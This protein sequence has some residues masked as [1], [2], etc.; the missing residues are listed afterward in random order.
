MTNPQKTTAAVIST[1]NYLLLA[2][3]S[4]KVINTLARDPEHR[5]R[6]RV[7]ITSPPYY[8]QRSYGDSPVEIGNEGQPTGYLNA[9][10]A[11]FLDARDLLTEDGHLWIVIGDVYLKGQKCRLPALLTD[12]LFRT[13]PGFTFRDEIIWVKKNNL[14]SSKQKAFTPAY[15]SILW[16]TK[17]VG[18][19]YYANVDPVRTLGNEAREGR[20]AVPTADE[21]QAEPVNANEAEVERLLDICRSAKPETPLSAFPSTAEICR[22][23]GF[24]PDKKCPIC[25]RK[26]R[27]HVT[28]KRVGGH[29]HYPIFAKCNPKGKNPG[30]V[31]EIST[32]AHH[33][34]EHFAIF[35]EELVDRILQFCTKPGDWI[36][37]PFMGRGTSG[38]AAMAS[39][40]RFTGID[41]Y[42]ENV[43]TAEKNVHQALEQASMK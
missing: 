16:F 38:I 3:D 30:N 15:E 25:Y 32:K 29:A 8:G 33:G 34:S 1:D 17:N 9:L 19:D 26:W 27:R 10:T 40:R 7:I 11:L 5:G 2:G 39:G 36:L 31:W 20:I 23:H 13:S 6:Y 43:A 35:P 4:R 37:D 28:R 12:I 42:E 18:N 21:I 14:F 41:L 24:E 22:A